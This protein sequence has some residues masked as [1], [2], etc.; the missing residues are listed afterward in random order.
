MA[1]FQVQPPT[2]PPA[3]PSMAL[4]P[5][6]PRSFRPSAILR[7]RVRLEDF[8]NEDGPNVVGRKMPLQSP[9]LLAQADADKRFVAQADRRASGDVDLAADVETQE[10]Q[11]ALNNAAVTSA[12]PA[13]ENVSPD[14]LSVEFYIV[15]T[16]LT[17]EL[18]GFRI[19]DKLTAAFALHD[20]PIDPRVV[21]AILVEGWLCTVG[22]DDF[23][24][25]GKWAPA[26]ARAGFPMFRGYA[27]MESLEVSDSDNQ[28]TLEAQ[29]L[30]QQLMVAELD[31]RSQAGHIPTGDE[32][33]TSFI[34]RI[35]STVPGFSG[36]VGDAIAVRMFPNV[37]PDKE[38]RIGRKML[39]R[40]MQSAQSQVA[41]NGGVPVQAAPVDEPG[42]D[43]A[44][45]PG[46][47]IPAVPKS[48]VE[49][50][51]V[52]DLVTRA[53]EMSG[54]LIPIYDPTIDPNAI[55]LMPPQNLFETSDGTGQRAAT[56]PPHL[57]FS[58]SFHRPD[59]STWQSS[60]RIMVWGHNVKSMK[61]QRQLGRIKAP[62]VRIV[63]YNPDAAP[64][65]RRLEVFFPTK[66]RSTWVQAEGTGRKAGAKGHKPVE[67]IVT[68]V[69][70]GVR[71]KDVLQQA[72]VS[73]YHSLSRKELSIAI[74][75][76]DMASFVDPSLPESGN[77]NPD[78]L[79]LRPG[80]EMQVR[81]ARNPGDDA[82]DRG[83]VVN[84]LSDLFR[85]QGDPQFLRG[86]LRGNRSSLIS[87]A[88]RDR[89]DQSLARLEAAYQSAKL[90]SSF[91]TKVVRHTFSNDEG[92]SCSMELINFVEARALPANVSTQDKKLND[93]MKLV[94]P[95]EA[96]RTAEQ[97]MID[98]N[99]DAMMR[100]NA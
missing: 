69:I 59:G 91:Y 54:A 72:A 80:M 7:M 71:D 64:K 84:E 6:V 1:D 81:V 2:S 21:R 70:H 86:L 74:E 60:A 9:R 24:D 36:A 30:E 4:H 50:M 51:T 93:Q 75:T 33:I 66:P 61:I 28:I 85:R 87:P 67:E 26:V 98:E 25:P 42:E 47:G 38:P 58:R 55:L 83:L 10:A 34:K 40:T 56:S 11:D 97:I 29:S 62:G 48:T 12:S 18:N 8:S 99:F 13:P 3:A 57:Q 52:W 96:D 45:T 95:G 16:S 5:G 22:L 32:P 88:A 79:R 77:D 39:L 35:V 90:T 41:A 14:D 23:A 68:F 92:Y 94:K 89:L 31:A 100:R 76:D 20:L 37:D 78:L 43:P 44:A 49:K 63:S 82:R 46:I 15:P 27:D 65:E 19:A 73:L 17:I 53:C